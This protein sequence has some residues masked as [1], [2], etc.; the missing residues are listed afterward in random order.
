VFVVRSLCLFLLIV[1]VSLAQRSQGV[2]VRGEYQNLAG[3]AFR[4]TVPDGLVAYRTAAP[5][6][7]HGFI[8]NLAGADHISV[9]GHYNAA[10]YATAREALGPTLAWISARGTISGEPNFIAAKLG[11]LPATEMTISYRDNKTA[12]E[13]VC[14]S[15]AAIRRI[16]P[17][18]GMGIIYG[19][20]LDASAERVADGT[21]VYSAVV[22]S[23]RL[24]PLTTY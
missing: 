11:G 15:I 3:Y 17:T 18:D 14:R 5:A 16:K 10:E 24:D 8:I 13:R 1:N 21:A 6:P 23:F 7:A 12:A 2:E 22:Q 9:D 20:L 4:A 19:I